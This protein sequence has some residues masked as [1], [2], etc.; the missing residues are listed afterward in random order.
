M[1]INTI[2]VYQGKLTKTEIAK[3]TARIAQVFPKFPKGMMNVLRE[4]FIENNFT[5][6]R[7]KAAVNHVIDTYEGWDKLPNIANFISYDKKVK[8]YT[9]DEACS[10]SGG[11]KNLT[12]VDI[13][14]EN[15]RWMLKEEVEK[16]KIKKWEKK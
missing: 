8:I 2:S 1:Q 3:Q 12:A 16:Y 4:R 7:L 13:G 11:M 10:Y 5:D 9:Y 6:S 15:P 14:F